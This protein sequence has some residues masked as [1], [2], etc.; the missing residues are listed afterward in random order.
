MMT[1]Y[2]KEETILV[3]SETKHTLDAYLMDTTNIVEMNGYAEFEFSFN[4]RTMTEHQ[5]LEEHLEVAKRQVQMMKPPHSQKVART[6]HLNKKKQ[7]VCSQLKAP[8]LND[9]VEHNSELY[10]RLATIT[11]HLREDPT[12]L[13]Y[14]QAD[15]VHLHPQLEPKTTMMN[16]INDGD[17]LEEIDF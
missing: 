15:W 17:V 2:E 1:Y 9:V 8:K 10:G 16:L 5:M 7:F 3:P 13:I 11:L 12:G 6:A 4:P 14:L